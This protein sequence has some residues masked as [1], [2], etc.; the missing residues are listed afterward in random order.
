MIKYALI[1]W[2]LTAPTQHYIIQ[3]VGGRAHCLG[4]LQWIK[5]VLA[6]EDGVKIGGLCLKK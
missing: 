4:Q 6:T 3:E 2:Y 1:Y 5:S